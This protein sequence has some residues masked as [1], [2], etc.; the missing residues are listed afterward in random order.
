MSALVS[1]IM[2]TRGRTQYAHMAVACFL[3]QRWPE[4][5]LIIL[6]DLEVRS[7]SVAPDFEGVH[8]HIHERPMKI[9]DKRNRCCALAKGSFVAHFDD[10]DFSA[11]ER[12]EDQ[13]DRLLATGAQLTGYSSMVIERGRELWMYTGRENFALGTSFL[14]RR[15]F[16]ER[17]RFRSLQQGEDSILL[18]HAQREGVIAS[19]PARH[20]MLARIHRANTVTKV[21]QPG[22]GWELIGRVAA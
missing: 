12:L 11:P 9:G 8:Y 13:M 19:A 1:C 14:Y 7:F 17:Y 21:P 10:D 5:E 3:R 2:P 15:E 18:G 4:K 22:S 6:D 20:N 16:W